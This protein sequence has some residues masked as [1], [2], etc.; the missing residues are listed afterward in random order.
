MAHVSHRALAKRSEY[1]SSCLNFD[2]VDTGMIKN[3]RCLSFIAILTSR[4][5]VKKSSLYAALPQILLLGGQQHSIAVF[6]F[7]IKWYGENPMFL[8]IYLNL[9]INLCILCLLKITAVW[10]FYEIY[11]KVVN[12]DWKHLHVPVKLKIPFLKREFEGK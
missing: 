8:L 4:F 10:Y 1:S 9:F 2:K 11:N 6:L 7:L 3:I 12:R 5:L